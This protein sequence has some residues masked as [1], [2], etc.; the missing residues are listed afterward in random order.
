MSQ[1]ELL[2][3]IYKKDEKAFTHLYDM[4]LI[5]KVKVVF[6]PGSLISPETHRSINFV[7]KTIITRKKT[8]PQ[9]IS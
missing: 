1:E 4:Y 5:T 6:T 9:I 7:L 2:V 8:F 3:L